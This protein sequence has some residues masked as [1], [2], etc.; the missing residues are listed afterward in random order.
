MALPLAPAYSPASAPCGTPLVGAT[1]PQATG[2]A[3]YNLL[4]EREPVA[5]ADL[6]LN[7]RI[8]LANF[9]AKAAQRFVLLDKDGKGYLVLS[10]LPKTAAQRRAD[11]AAGQGGPKPPG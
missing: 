9:K 11:R 1:T 3:A 5:G 10:E 8:T 7:S 2:A 6:S 4:L